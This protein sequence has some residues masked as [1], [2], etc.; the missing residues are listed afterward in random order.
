VFEFRPVV[1]T[2]RRPRLEIR[3]SHEVGNRQP[4]EVSFHHAS[5]LGSRND[6]SHHIGVRMTQSGDYTQT[7]MVELKANLFT[8]KLTRTNQNTLKTIHQTL[9]KLTV[10]NSEATTMLTF[11]HG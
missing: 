11:L 6:K 8:P 7:R 1:N 10:R 5:V 2:R 4:N 9:R 3:L